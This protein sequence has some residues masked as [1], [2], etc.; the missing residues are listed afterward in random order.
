VV[1][2]PI[3]MSRTPEGPIERWPT[4]GQHTEEVLRSDLGLD[5]ADLSALRA[6]GAIG[7]ADTA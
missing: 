4:L 3:K 6:S 2:N 5:D 1:G 7:A